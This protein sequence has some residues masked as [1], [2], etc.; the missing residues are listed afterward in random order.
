MSSLSNSHVLFICFV[1]VCVLLGGQYTLYHAEDSNQL[2]ESL[3]GLEQQEA[4]TELLDEFKVLKHA[5]DDI[6]HKIDANQPVIHNYTLSEF[7]KDPVGVI[8]AS[9]SYTNVATYAHEVE[10]E[11]E[12][13]K[14]TLGLYEEKKCKS[15]DKIYFLKTSKTGSTSLANILTR[16]GLRRNGTTFLMGESSNGGFFFAN[17]Y[18]PFNAETCFLGSNLPKRPLFDISYVHMRYNKTAI[19]MLMHPDHKKITILRDPFE[20]FISS[21]R[22][23]PGFYLD[24]R[25]RLPM[26]APGGKTFPGSSTDADF[27]SEMEEFL[28]KLRALV[29]NWIFEIDRDF[30][31]IVILERLDTSMAVMMIKF[32]WNVDDVIN[33]KLNSMRKETKTLTD[34]SKLS[35]KALN[36]ADFKLYDYFNRRLDREVQKIAKDK[37][38]YYEKLINKRIDE[39]K[40]ECLE[41]DQATG[42]WISSIRLK[43]EKR[44]N[45]TCYLITKD[46]SNLISFEHLLRWK[47][48]FPEYFGSAYSGSEPPKDMPPKEKVPKFCKGPQNWREWFDKQEPYVKNVFSWPTT[49]YDIRSEWPS[50]IKEFVRPFTAEENEL[51]KKFPTTYR[52]I[53]N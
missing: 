50:Y 17:A 31:H 30:D 18:M 49:E 7:I 26:Y 14:K 45:Q 9:E 25:K 47:K 53:W 4:Y 41:K 20:N 33:L 29:D 32:C 39:Y 52:R 11:L 10:A 38:D 36:W 6:T 37:V 40:E 43:P 23:Y 34:K 42:G 35:L 46:N 13:L 22:Y 21:W 24:M 1:L 16:Y 12:D 5:I 3:V 8:E 2:N 19:N 44:K 28:E 15:Q 51:N 48:Q 27:L